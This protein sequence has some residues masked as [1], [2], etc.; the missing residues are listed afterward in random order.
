MGRQQIL[1]AE[2][3]FF[4]GGGESGAMPTIQPKTYWVPTTSAVANQF[5]Y[6][7]VR[8][9]GTLAIALSQ[10]PTIILDMP[11]SS[12]GRAPFSSPPMAN[13]KFIHYACSVRLC[14]SVQGDPSTLSV[15]S[16][17]YWQFEGWLDSIA[18]MIRGGAAGSLLAKS[19]VTPSFPSG[20]Q[21]TTWGEDFT[22]AETV[23]PLE[24]SLLLTG[25]FSI[26][27]EEQVVA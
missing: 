9:G 17:A 2:Q 22:I 11:Q 1:R 26:Q 13:M 5:G 6:V 7:T 23:Q 20:G 3:E 12:E 16:D 27:C 18:Q 25:R 8:I 10:L 21:V 4:A 19:L 14:A 24:T 15:G